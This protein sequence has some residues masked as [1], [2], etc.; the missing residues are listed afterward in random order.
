MR[1]R[2]HVTGLIGVGLFGFA[3]NAVLGL[4]EVTKLPPPEET[5]GS[6]TAGVP[7]KAGS[8][9][10]GSAGT[11]SP[12]AGSS[13]ENPVGDAG[14]G[15]ESGAG[16][17]PTRE[18]TP[19][20]TAPCRQV[21]PTLLG[22]CGDG[23]VR[24]GTDGT[25]GACDVTPSSEDSCEVEDD[26]ADCDGTPNSGCPC[27]EGQTRACGPETE[28]GICEFGV[29]SCENEEWQA[30]V[31]ATLPSARNCRSS[32]DNDCDG[33]PDNVIDDECPC[34]SDGA[35]RCV[36]DAPADWLGPVALAT[37]AATAAAPS[38]TATGYERAVLSKFGS[39]DEGSAECACSCSAPGNMQCT[40]TPGLHRVTSSVSCAQI[41]L[42][43][44]DPLEYDVPNNTCVNVPSG[45]L[46]AVGHSFSSSGSCTPQPTSDIDDAVFKRRMVACATNEESTA[47]CG[48][49][50]L[51]V[52]NLVAPLEKFCVYREGE[53]DCP[54]D[55]PYTERTVY[56]DELEDDRTC[57]TCTCGSASGL[58]EGAISLT[59]NPGGTC[60]GQILV[61][62]LGYGACTD[63]SATTIAVSGASTPV[64]NCT[65]SGGRLQGSVRRNGPTTVCCEP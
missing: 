15:G 5:A 57:S 47:G 1:S 19:A 50:Q 9:S 55:A 18:C 24:C 41:G 28:D 56:L 38:C 40:G 26:D 14:R 59:S 42:T 8:S 44:D 20:E 33:E 11:G 6:G 13:G 22:N 4:E 43:F 54:N 16:N 2:S 34:D 51:C 21:D 31:G 35:H 3:C 60:E 10:G 45:R 48:A 58:C 37:A 63:T 49:A 29:S 61:A 32:G 46:K 65:P 39:V 52:P 64:G 17:E 36:G 23:T 12:V 27:V 30:C 7:G 62:Q 25:W 53:H